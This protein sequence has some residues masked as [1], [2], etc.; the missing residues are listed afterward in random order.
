MASW[1]DDGN[2]PSS[3]NDDDRLGEAIETYLALIEQG[4]APEP[5]DFADRYPDLRDDIRAA[6]D[7]LELVHGLVGQAS[8]SGAGQARAEG[9]DGTWN[10]AAGS[11]AT[12]WSASWAAGA[13]GRSTR[14]STSGWTGPWPSRS[15]APTPPPTPRP[16]DG[17]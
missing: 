5:E 1:N 6:L 11:R 15:W 12:A 16:G 2:A 10:R 13:W 8:G 7:G 9:R 4:T 14:R 17:S 3:S